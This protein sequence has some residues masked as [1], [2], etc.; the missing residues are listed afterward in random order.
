VVGIISWTLAWS[1][2]V[3]CCSSNDFHA[4]SNSARYERSV[5]AV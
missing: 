2:S 3:P 1:S 4:S 5:Y